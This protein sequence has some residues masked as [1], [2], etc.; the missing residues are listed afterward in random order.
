VVHRQRNTGY[1][2]EFLIF[3]AASPSEGLAIQASYAAGVTM[4][5][6][7]G[8]TG[9]SVGYPAAYGETIAVSASDDNGAIAGFSSRGHNL[10]NILSIWQTPGY[11]NFVD[12]GRYHPAPIFITRTIFNQAPATSL[13]YHPELRFFRHQ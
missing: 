11:N 8:N 4:V 5:A 12:R 2:Y 3:C 9:G 7:A 10:L 1:Q 6:A 13:R